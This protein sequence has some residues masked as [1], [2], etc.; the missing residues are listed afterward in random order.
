M[1]KPLV[2]I[3]G[4]SSGIG[5]AAARLFSEAGYPLALLARNQSAMEAL[6]LPSTLCFSADVTNHH[7]V[8]EAIVAA[9]NQYGSADCLINS[10]GVVKAGEFCEIDNNEYEKIVKVNLL[11]TINTIETVLPSMQKRKS[12]TI[13][14]ISSLSDRNDRTFVAVYGATKAAV[15]SLGGALRMANAKYGVRVCNVAPAM[16][17]TPMVQKANFSHHPTLNPEDIAKTLLWIYQQPPSVCIRD[18]VI[19]HTHY[20]P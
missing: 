13:I 2:I 15:K 12:G 18:I 14:N 8:K 6:N 7:A 11:G 17:M 3:T 4:A 1:K 20:E 9:E 16:V 19:A 5:A 10:A